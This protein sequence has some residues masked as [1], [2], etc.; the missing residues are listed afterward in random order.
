MATNKKPGGKSRKKDI[1]SEEIVERHLHDSKDVITPEDI[2]NVKVPPSEAEEI[3]PEIIELEEKK[4][5]HGK[6]VPEK[7]ITT[8]WDVIDQ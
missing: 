4:D 7:D 8:S 6:N 2:Q 3:D 1:T 5:D